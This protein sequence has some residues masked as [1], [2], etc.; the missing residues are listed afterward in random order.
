MLKAAEARNFAPT[1]RRFSSVAPIPEPDVPIETP[2]EKYERQCRARFEQLDKEP[3]RRLISSNFGKPPPKLELQ[4]CYDDSEKTYASNVPYSVIFSD[5]SNTV[6]NGVL[7]AKGYA[8]VQG[9]NYPAKV[10]FGNE[11]EKLTAESKLPLQ[12]QQFDLALNATAKQVADHAI[13]AKEKAKQINSI[14]IAESFKAAVDSKIAELEA[15]SKAFDNL[16]YLSQSWAIAKATKTGISKGVTEYLPDFGEFG[17]L[18]DAADID[19]A[20]LIEA[21]S[22]GNIDELESKLQQWKTRAGEGFTKGCNTMET[23]ILLLS[24]P[25]SREMLASL[26]KRI[27]DALPNDQVVEIVAYQSTQMGIDITVVNGGTALGTFAG[28]VGGLVAAGTLFSATS[29]RKAG[30]AL[31]GVVETVADIS[32]SLKKINNQHEA[33]PYKKE[34]E[35]SLNKG[36]SVS[37]IE[38]EQGKKGSWNKELNGKLKANT[39]YKVGNYTYKTDDLGRVK[40]VSGKLDLTTQDRNKYQQGKAGKHDGI[41]DGL[42][43][44]EGGH[45]I[46]S[47]FNGPGEQINYAAMNANLNKGAWKRMENKWAE[48]LKGNPPKKV[49]VSID[50]IYKG[51]SQRPEAFDVFFDIDGEEEFLSMKNTP[52]G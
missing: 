41:K 35:L 34:N 36:T 30:K 27:L 17:E 18:M 31:E 46:A 37:I 5:P 1:S 16:S 23:L 4:L 13:V 26:P 22:S 39:K 21:I 25:T 43:D 12:Y 32:K 8:I 24:D 47:I 11:K 2:R 40:S 38:F 51:D 3:K 19:I 45:I 10:K 44:D 52:G 9:P 6:V 48:A 14:D 29:T 15:E 7:D 20:I 33:V 50:A 42:N 28:G 49:N